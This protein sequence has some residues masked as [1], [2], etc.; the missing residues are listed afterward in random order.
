M[1]EKED[2]TICEIKNKFKNAQGWVNLSEK[3]TRDIEERQKI[4]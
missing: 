2:K 1:R 3:L 4:K